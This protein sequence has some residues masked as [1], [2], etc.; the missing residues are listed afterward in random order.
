[1]EKGDGALRG[2]KK[3][4]KEESVFWEERGFSFPFGSPLGQGTAGHL[5]GS[6]FRDP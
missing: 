5:Q 6:Y 2:E 1:L 3:C 4:V